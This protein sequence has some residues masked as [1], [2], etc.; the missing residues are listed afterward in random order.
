[1]DRHINAPLMH[2]LRESCVQGIMY[3]LQE[4]FTPQEMLHLRMDKALNRGEQLP[5]SLENNI[6]YYMR[7]RLLQEKADPSVQEEFNKRQTVW[8]SMR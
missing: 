6:I 5:V 2:R 8:I 7:S 4:L 1:M 3:I